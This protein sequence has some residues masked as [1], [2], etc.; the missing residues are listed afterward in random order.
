MALK[1]KVRVLKDMS[2]DE[3]VIKKWPTI[4]W[5]M[6]QLKAHGINVTMDQLEETFEEYC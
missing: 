3:Q 4:A 2:K 1:M 5:M 6:K